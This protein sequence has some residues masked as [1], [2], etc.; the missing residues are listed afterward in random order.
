MPPYTPFLE[1]TFC[2]VRGKTQDPLD[3]GSFVVVFVVVVGGL[4]MCMFVCLFSGGCSCFCLGEGRAWF[5]QSYL[6]VRYPDVP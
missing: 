6:S 5:Q 1:V 4:L 3:L 2:L